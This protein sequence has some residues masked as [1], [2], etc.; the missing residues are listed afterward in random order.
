MITYLEAP[1]RANYTVNGHEVLIVAFYL[2]FYAS[3]VGSS[4]SD[5]PKA[6]IVADDG[7]MGTAA[8]AELNVNWRFNDRT[9]RWLDVDTGDEL[10]SDDDDGG[11]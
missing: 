4:T 3:T 8:V 9:R 1:L 11:S 10:G 7:F 5:A 6:I 2:P